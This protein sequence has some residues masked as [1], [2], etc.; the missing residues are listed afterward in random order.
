MV[1]VVGIGGGI[2]GIAQLHLQ[3]DINGRPGRK[4]G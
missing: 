4:N 3:G 2:A 1:V